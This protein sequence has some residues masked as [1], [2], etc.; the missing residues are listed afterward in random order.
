MAVPSPGVWEAGAFSPL[1]IP[2]GTEVEETLEWTGAVPLVKRG[3]GRLVLGRANSHTG[4][5]VIEVGEVVVRHAGALGNGRVEVRAGATL[6]LELGTGRLD[7]GELVVIPGARLDLGHGGL[8][9]APGTLTAAEVRALLVSARSGGSWTGAGIGTSAVAAGRSVGYRV[10]GDGTIA[11]AWA[12]LGDANLDGRLNSS[13]INMI[14]AAGRYGLSATDGGWWQGDFNYD[15]RVNSSDINQLLSTGLLNAGTYLPAAGTGLVASGMPLSGA[16]SLRLS[17]GVWAALGMVAGPATPAPQF[18]VQSQDVVQD[19]SVTVGDTSQPAN[20][21]P[22]N[23]AAYLKSSGSRPV[24]TDTGLSGAESL[25]YWA[26]VWYASEQVVGSLS[27]A[28]GGRRAKLAIWHRVG[29]V[30]LGQ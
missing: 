30:S 27:D 16:D 12:A 10:L 15:G 18:S 5:T 23:A 20:S 8:R 28:V 17:A 9:L 3:A 6:R 21:E 22:D 2:A 29:R 14:L 1:T 26:G 13:D 19:A 7:V 4:G 25:R 11:V 24:G